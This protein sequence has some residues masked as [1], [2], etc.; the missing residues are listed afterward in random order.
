MKQEKE[1]KYMVATRCFTYAHAPYIEDALRGF[2]MQE[3]MFPVVYIIV[4]DASIDGEQ[5]VL[6]RWAKENLNGS[7]GAELW[8]GMPYGQLAVS[9]LKG[10]PQSTFVI[11]LLAENY[12]SSKRS[13]Q[14]FEYISEWYDCVKYQALCEGDDYWTDRYKLQKQVDYLESHPECGMVYTQAQQYD[15]ETG[16]IIKGTAGQTN[17][18]DLLCVSNKVMTLTVMFR[19]ALYSKC[20]KELALPIGYKCYDIHY[21]LYISKHSDI[22]YI[23]EITAVYRI[24][25][26]SASHNSDTTKLAAFII[27]LYEIRFFYANHYGYTDLF[28]DYTKKTINDLFRLSAQRNTNI[29][30]MIF[31]FAK[32]KKALSFPVLLK[33]LFYS[34]RIG[35]CYHRRKY[36]DTITMY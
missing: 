18:M 21:W 6:R 24:L 22:H 26:N 23:D 11:L 27:D 34:T 10:K 25:K 28:K 1:Y 17:F 7:D 15:Q 36:P 35:R 9:T 30:Y 32:K 12:Y 19:T 20:L 3:T 13:L 31:L 33:C 4:D 2:A 8:Q 29:S 14:K 5:D 16:V